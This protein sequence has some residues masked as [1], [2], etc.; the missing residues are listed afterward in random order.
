MKPWTTFRST[1]GIEVGHDGEVR[2]QPNHAPTDPAR[3][4]AT[5]APGTGR[6]SVPPRVG[7]SILDRANALNGVDASTRFH[8]VLERARR[9]EA[10]GYRRMWTAE[11]HAVPGIIGA[12]PT[13]LMAAI[14]AATSH[15]RVGSGGI[16]V[17]AHQ[18]L[19]IAEQ[20]ATLEALHPGRID[21]GLGRSLGFTPPVRRALRQ[22]KDAA[23]RFGEDVREVQAFLSGRAEITAQPQNNAA[24]ALYVLAHGASLDIAASAGLAVVVGGPSLLTGAPGTRHPGIERYRTTFQP[25]AWWSAPHV[26]ASANIAVA[27]SPD[28]AQRLLLPEAWAL[29]RSRSTGLFEPLRPAEQI[30]REIRQLSQRDQDRVWS[31]VGQGISGA[32]E[33]VLPAVQALVAHTGV[34]EILVTGGMYDLDG[35]ARSDELLAQALAEG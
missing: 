34:E 13:L 19:V 20:I 21:I 27:E 32:P 4:A 14:A 33:Q 31:A 8:Q 35:Q 10:I 2:P 9:L 5:T 24:T 17:P 25:S 26:I 23:V 1:L 29:A 22:D 15:I 28:A 18:P 7:L 3:E 11:H 12:A 30:E 16:M 6:V